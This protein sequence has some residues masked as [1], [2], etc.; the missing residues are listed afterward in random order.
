M[1]N[2]SLIDGKFGGIHS[3][4]H[5]IYVY[6]SE[7][8]LVREISLAAVPQ[9]LSQRPRL[10]RHWVQLAKGTWI[11]SSIVYLNPAYTRLFH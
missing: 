8:N 7:D 9:I 6:N 11:E 10:I 3:L 4:A 2:C 1:N 5:K